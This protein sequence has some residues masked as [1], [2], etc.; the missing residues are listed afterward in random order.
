MSNNDNIDMLTTIRNSTMKILDTLND[1][2]RTTLHDL[3]D[4]VVADSGIKVS[5]TSGVVSMII[6]E[7]AAAGNGTIERGR[8]GGIFKGAKKPERIDMRPRC[9]M[10]HQVYRIKAQ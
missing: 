3:T 2:D 1:G 4:K 6:H 8:R 10:C 5:I 9:E 7:W